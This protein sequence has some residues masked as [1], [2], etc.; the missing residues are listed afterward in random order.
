AAGSVQERRIGQSLH[1]S[2]RNQHGDAESRDL[3]LHAGEGKGQDKGEAGA[4]EAVADDKDE[5]AS[6]REQMAEMQKKLDSLGK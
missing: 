5:L 4:A 3:G 1:P 2:C 6:L